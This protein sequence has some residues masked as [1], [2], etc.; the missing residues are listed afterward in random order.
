MKPGL[1]PLAFALLALPA[2]NAAADT[3]Y[4]DLNSPSPTPPYT[5]WLTAA[6]N[7]QDAVDAADAGDTVLVNHGVYA[8]G[9]KAVHG[10]MTNR[11]AVDKVLNVQSVNG[12]EVT[13]IQ[14]YQMPGTTSG[15]GEAAVRCVYLA[16][17]ASISGFTITNGATQD[18]TSVPPPI[19]GNGG[20]IFC[21]SSSAIVSNCVIVENVARWQ[22][23]GVHSGSLVD[24]R[25][26][27]NLA[28]IGGGGAYQ[29]IIRSSV[30][31]SNSATRNFGG[32]AQ[33]S[34]L[35]DCLV[36]ANSAGF[37][38]GC[39]GSTL[40]NCTVAHNTPMFSG[41][42]VRGGAGDNCVIY[43]NSVDNYASA[44]LN[45]CCVTPIPVGGVGNITNAPIFVN[46]ND[47]SD[48]RLQS[49]SPCINAG[50]NAYV[51]GSTDLD[52]NPRISGGTVDMGAYEFQSPGSVLSYA[53]AQQYGLPTDG[54]ADFVDTDGEGA[55]NWQEWHADTVPTNAAS[56]LRMAG[57]SNA[58]T[59]LAVTWDSVTNR[60]YW[61][62]RADDFGIAPS[63]QT[64]ATNLPGVAGAKTLTDTSATNDGPYFYRV[65]V[66]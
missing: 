32:G 13:L 61:L 40:V 64:I 41:G 50:N 56:A 57:V 14:G 25:V 63:F 54:S 7:I 34:A 15:Y 30:L 23:G 51:S 9:G 16:D 11:V 60:N 4:V 19:M 43:F 24:C 38:A 10:T 58:P 2:L 3:H 47:G 26:F 48:L 39:D 35:R 45:N 17:D 8:T 59:G 53:W 46:T 28:V 27:G 33:A 22:G 42:G 31:S 49:N 52:G 44:A 20:G 62:E 21:A 55:N 36:I 29:S 66:Q 65:G 5:N 37:G 1:L 18:S 6:T 12:P